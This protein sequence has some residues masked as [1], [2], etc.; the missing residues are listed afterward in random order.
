MRR[1]AVHFGSQPIAK[2]WLERDETLRVAADRVRVQGLAD[3]MHAGREVT[4][5]ESL[6]A[7]AFAGVQ[8]K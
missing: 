1:G 8:V 2:P 4:A 5:C 6:R 3:S 7:A